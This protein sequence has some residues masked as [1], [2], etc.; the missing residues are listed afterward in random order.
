MPPPPRT[1]PARPARRWGGAGTRRALRGGAAAARERSPS[2]G[3]PAPARVRRLDPRRARSPARP[4]AP[5]SCGTGASGGTAMA[6]SDGGS[7]VCSVEGGVAATPSARRRRD[8]LGLRRGGRRRVGPTARRPG[9]RRLSSRPRAGGG[10]ATP[11]MVAARGRIGGGA[12]GGAGGAGA[13]GITTGAAARGAEAGAWCGRRHRLVGHRG[14]PALGVEGHLD[15]DGAWRRA[16]RG[17][18]GISPRSISSRRALMRS[19]WAPRTYAATRIAAGSFT[20][21]MR[22]ISAAIA[23][24]EANLFSGSRRHRAAR[25]LDQRRGPRAACGHRRL[26]DAPAQQLR[27]DCRRLQR[28]RTAACRSAPPR[29]SRPRRRRRRARRP[30][31]RP[32]ASR[33]RGTRCPPRSAPQPVAC[34]RGTAAPAARCR[35]GPTIDVLGRQVAVH[36]LHRLAAGVAQVVHRAKAR[37]AR[38]RARAA[39]SRARAS[40][41]RPRRA[42]TSARRRGS[43]PST[44]TSSPRMLTSRT[45]ARLGC[46]SVAMRRTS[47]TQSAILGPRSTRPR[48]PPFSTTTTTRLVTVGPVSSSARRH[49]VCEP[50][51]PSGRNEL[52]ALRD[53]ERRA[54]EGTATT[55]DYH[56]VGWPSCNATCTNR[57]EWR[58]CRRPTLGRTPSPGLSTPPQRCPPRPACLASP[59]SPGACSRTTSP[60]S[61][62]APTCARR[63]R[64]PG[65]GRALAAVQRRGRAAL[66]PPRRRWSSCRTGFRAAW[67][68]RSRWCCSSGRCGRIPAGHVVRRGAGATMA[69]MVV[70]SLIGAGLVLFRARGARRVD[71]AGAGGV[72]APGNTF[73]LLASTALTAWWASGGARPKVRGQGA[74]AWALARAARGDVPG[75]RQRRGD[76]ARRH[77]LPARDARGGLRA[78]SGA[79]ARTCSCGCAPCTRRWR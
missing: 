6:R 31:R 73:L 12:L 35:R 57:R 32:A 55:L 44:S 43:R 39:P 58:Q 37:R 3:S 45:R 54:E 17:A 8:R 34:A 72:P 79:R 42:P 25:H 74:A 69:L 71:E 67:R 68:W 10:G 21:A 5:R 26:R 13:A 48:A 36:E 64:A 22:R 53:T 40:R 30:T 2:A 4:R 38:R 29:A 18:L 75:R 1:P 52:H 27:D 41:P 76:G 24:A 7:A 9:C 60:S 51:S 16:T 28:P 66:A 47:R 49:Q 19:P 15:V 50:R 20:P 63:D 46:S 33:A 23:A 70:E 77:A 14:H 65:C 78:G 62:G 59:A 11:A 61:P 56:R